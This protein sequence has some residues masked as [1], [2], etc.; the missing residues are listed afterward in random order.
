[1]AG[2]EVVVRPVVFPNIR[3]APARVLP[4]EDDPEKGICTIGGGGPGSAGSS[5]S[6]SVSVSRQKPQQE[7]ARQYQVERVYQKDG[8]DTTK[9]GGRAGGAKINRNNYVDVERLSKVRLNTSDKDGQDIAI[10]VIYADP[11][12]ADNV[13]I[14]GTDLVRNS[15]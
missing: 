8:N 2:L 11:P 14:I 10:K 5:A 6:W 4:P 13:E 12:P 15:S 3:S 1:M 9:S 7:S